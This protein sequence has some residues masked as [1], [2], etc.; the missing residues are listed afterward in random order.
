MY[1]N[2]KCD[3]GYLNTRAMEWNVRRISKNEHFGRYNGDRF[4]SPA[5]TKQ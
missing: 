5:N 4:M 3:F 1:S 2:F